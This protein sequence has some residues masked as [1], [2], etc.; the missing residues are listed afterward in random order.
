[1][2]S[3]FYVLKTHVI[4]NKYTESLKLLQVVSTWVTHLFSGN[5]GCAHTDGF[6]LI[7]LMR[8]TGPQTCQFSW[9][10]SLAYCDKATI[11]QSNHNLSP[12]LRG[13]QLLKLFIST[14][15]PGICIDGG[16][17]V[18]E[19]KCGRQ[20]HDSSSTPGNSSCALWQRNGHWILIPC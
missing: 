16:K 19:L 10:V 11:V 20:G 5:M 17:G 9:C 8:E 4:T 6:S 15:Y 18:W 7:S 2:I 13:C 1:M 3:V 14:Q 12:E